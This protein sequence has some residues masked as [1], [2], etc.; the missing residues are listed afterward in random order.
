MSKITNQNAR[1]YLE[2]NL[3]PE[4]RA[5]L[6]E[7]LVHIQTSGELSKYWSAVDKQNFEARKEAKK[8]DR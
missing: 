1:N 6:K 7:L 2:K 4:V 5:S 8:L 3:F